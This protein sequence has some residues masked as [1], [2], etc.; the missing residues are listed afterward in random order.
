[1]TRFSIIIPIY[2]EALNI[3]KLISEIYQT[4]GKPKEYEIIIVDDSSKD[5]SVKTIKSFQNEYSV[6][7]IEHNK[8]LGQSNSILSGIK[9]SKN[10]LIVTIDGDG[11]NN[12]KDIPALLE[13]YISLKDFYLIGGIR[14]KRKDNLIKILSSKIANLIRSNF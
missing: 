14:K 3:K 2:N 13:K 4:L 8:N 11:Q 12:P 10:N 5:S 1:M 9:N 6:N 7:L